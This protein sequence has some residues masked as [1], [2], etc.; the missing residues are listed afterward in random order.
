MMIDAHIHADTRPYEDFGQMSMTGVKAIVSCAHDPMEMNKSNV[1]IEHINK[2]VYQEPKRVARQNVKLY[3]A[4]GIHPR[5][6][7][8]DY[9]NVLEKLPD[10][11]E[12][13]HVVA[14][15][16]IGLDQVTIKQEE[17]FI[18][19]LQFAD[20]NKYNIIVH[21][22]R[23]NKPEV[24]TR[25]IELMDEYIDPKLVQLDHIDYSIIQMAID[26]KYSLGITVQPEKMSPTETV[27]LL[28]EYGFDKFVLDSDMSSAPSDVMSLAKT[29]QLLEVGGYKKSD[30]EKVTYK[31]VAKFHGI[32]V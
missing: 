30:I 25:T 13:E 12:L 17:V 10:Y 15:G 22:P 2:I 21:T 9:E 31:N 29:R 16:E 24:T 7:P 4:V 28:D 26:K 19:Q 11:M 1:T 32:E 3:A 20:E 23:G 27:Q 5:A 18:K 6:I 14:V 8:E